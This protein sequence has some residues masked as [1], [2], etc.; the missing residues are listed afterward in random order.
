MNKEIDLMD[1][2]FTKGILMNV[3]NATLSNPN[4]RRLMEDPKVSFDAVIAEWLYTEV[5]SGYE[6]DF[7]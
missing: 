7:K 4:V 3:A 2:T 5:Y 1:M 6:H